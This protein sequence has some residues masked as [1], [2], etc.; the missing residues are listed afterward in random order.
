VRH[1]DHQ[2]IILDGWH[3]VAMNTEQQA[4]AMRQVTFLD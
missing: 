4:A 2:T 3:E 1:R